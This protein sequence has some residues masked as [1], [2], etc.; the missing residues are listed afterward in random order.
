M[1]LSEI[2]VAAGCTFEGPDDPDLT[3]IRSLES[4]GGEHL[5]F[6][7]EDP[8]IAKA[9]ASGAG[10]FIVGRKTLSW[11]KPLIRSD[12]PYLSYARAVPLFYCQPLPEGPFVHPTAVID[13]TATLGEAC[14]IGAHVVIGAGVRLGNRVRILPNSTVYPGVTA[15]DDVL[16]HSNCVIR[17]NCALGNRVILQNGCIIGA[18]GFGFAPDEKGVFHKIPQVGRVV[19]EDDVEVQA[20]TCVDRGALD[21]T[22]IRRGTKLDNLIQIGHGVQIGEDT[23]IASQTGIAGSTQVG[24]HCMIA[25]QVGIVGHRKVGDGAK[26]YPKSGIPGDVE[27]GSS[28]WGWAATDRK[29]YIRAML[30]F[31]KLPDLQSR[32]RSLEKRLE[33]LDGKDER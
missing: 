10:A 25:G 31:P 16:V 28:L 22:I 11:G 2:A 24:A 13:P 29:Q 4:A 23:V 1:K 9:K 6:L 32:I 3:G 7:V 33:T 26:I 15:G 12:N 21:D 8:Q 30:L 14:H 18:D 27:P 19:L 20:N 5:S 17:E